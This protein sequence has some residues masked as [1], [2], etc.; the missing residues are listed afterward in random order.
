MAGSVRSL[1]SAVLEELAG[2][3]C[4][5]HRILHLTTSAGVQVLLAETLPGQEEIS[6][7][8]HFQIAALSLNAAIPL[9][10]LLGRPYY[11]NC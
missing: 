11:L 7:G 2:A 1:A 4:Q 8:F 3:F 6:R 5:D 9:R 10:P